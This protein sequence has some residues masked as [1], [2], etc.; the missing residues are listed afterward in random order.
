MGLTAAQVAVITAYDLSTNQL[1]AA[2]YAAIL[3][4]AVFLFTITHLAR[5]AY[6]K[7]GSQ[8]TIFRVLIS[9]AR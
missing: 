4:G 6:H 9:P 8:G 3:G 2:T 5:L 7:L 1:R